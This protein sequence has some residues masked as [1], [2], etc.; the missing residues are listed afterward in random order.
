M[1]WAKISAARYDIHAGRQAGSV[2][3]K[4]GD[5]VYKQQMMDNFRFSSASIASPL[6]KPN[7]TIRGATKW[8]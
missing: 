6:A 1:V 8:I 5:D 4:S 3:N 2:Y 7:P